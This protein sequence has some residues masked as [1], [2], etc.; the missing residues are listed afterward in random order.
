MAANF[1]TIEELE[2]AVNAI[3][4]YLETADTKDLIKAQ[5]TIKLTKEIDYSIRTYNEYDRITEA[6]NKGTL[7]ETEII[8]SDHNVIRMAIMLLNS[9]GEQYLNNSEITIE[10]DDRFV[11]GTSHT[12]TYIL[13]LKDPETHDKIFK[14]NPT[15]DDKPYDFYSQFV[16]Q[17]TFYN[18]GAI[19][20]TTATSW[21]SFNKCYQSPTRKFDF[22][23]DL[24]KKNHMHSVDYIIQILYTGEVVVKLAKDLKVLK[25]FTLKTKPEMNFYLEK[26]LNLLK[27]IYRFKHRNLPWDKFIIN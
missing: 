8:E 12:N 14:G 17:Y 18:N 19:V 3:F 6:A 10:D 24:W 1:I 26:Y 11:G 25:K 22:K 4:K 23:S 20:N 5:D 16:Q 9:F 15:K 7:L 13:H 2:T 21:D 27:R